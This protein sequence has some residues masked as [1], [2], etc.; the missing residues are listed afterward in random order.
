MPRFVAGENVIPS[1]SRA[2]RRTPLHGARPDAPREYW[3]R[4]VTA[5]S[6]RARLVAL[7]VVGR[8]A[9][10]SVAVACVATGCALL[11]PTLPPPPDIDRTVRLGQGWTREEARWFHHV[12]QGTSTFNIPYT[13]LVALEQPRVTL[14]ESPLLIEPDYMSRFGFIPSARGPGNPDG[15]PVGF[16]RDPQARDPRSDQPEDAAGFT[17]AACHTGRI[18]Y[19]GVGLVVD[20]GPAM[21]D[22]GK[23]RKAL[24]LA[25]VYT[26]YIPGRFG[27]FADRVLGPDATDEQ[28]GALADALASFVTNARASVATENE[29][30]AGSVEEGFGRLDAIGRIGNTVFGS[31]LDERNIEPLMAPVAYPHIWDASWFDWVQYN[32]SIRQP[33]VR[34]GGEALGVSARVNLIG[35]ASELYRSN[36][37]V[38]NLAD[39]E[40]QLAGPAAWQGLRPPPWPAEVLGAIDR[41]KAQSGG[42]LYEELCQD[43]HMPPVDSP[44]MAAQR[45]PYFTE[46]DAFGRRYLQVRMI[47]LSYVGTDPRQAVTMN[48]RTVDLAL[49]GSAGRL[50]EPEVAAEPSEPKDFGRA[51]A[52]ITESVVLR[53]YEEN[54]IPESE[55]LRMDGYR[56]NDVRAPLAYKARPLNGVWATPP[57]LHNGSVP[58][59]YS[60]LSPVSERPARF[61]LGSIEFDPVRVGYVS[62]RI[63]GGFQVDTSEIGS[64][65]AGHEFADGP[66]GNGRIGRA[67]TED[68]RLALIEYLK[69][70]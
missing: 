9:V 60:L 5:R 51:L 58:D 41:E 23:F 11:P 27:R 1:E 47:D 17:C 63:R 68:E 56:G 48:E 54:D 15:L 40:M 61:W 55:R 30:T 4:P 8:V 10:A 69:T 37:Q 18:A 42:K 57:Y 62:S 46:E 38:K 39:L 65:N 35:P 32:G 45:P 36:V 14:F 50:M 29:R 53:W 59:L 13:W 64:S 25:V 21:T 28:R 2:V 49:L 52:D 22:L 70:L 24:G 12:S 26:R 31:A 7:L 66:R 20:G 67:L 3:V 19:E 34:N 16:A 44:E 43:C 33:M 6:R